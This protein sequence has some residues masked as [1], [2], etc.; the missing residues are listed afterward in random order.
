MEYSEPELIIPAL[1]ILSVLDE[2][3]STTELKALLR[4]ELNPTGSDLELLENRTDDRFSQKVRNLTGSHRT[5]A[6]RGLAVRDDDGNHEITAEGL[7]YLREHKPSADAITSQ[8]FD[9][10]DRER[11][12]DTDYKDLLIEEGAANRVSKTVYK[13]SQKLHEYARDHFSDEGGKIVCRGCGFEGSSVYGDVGLGLIEMHHLVP[14]HLREGENEGAQLEEAIDGV[15][16]LCPN[17]HRMVH[18]QRDQLLTLDELRF[19][20]GYEID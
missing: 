8:G 11:V 19:L 5:L 20:T 2:A 9:I 1:E 12:A 17:C 16:P 13:R 18:R 6:N 3:L 7:K 10:E 4:Q 15:A 14:L